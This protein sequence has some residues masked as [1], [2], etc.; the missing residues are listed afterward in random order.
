MLPKYFEGKL[1]LS[2]YYVEQWMGQLQHP[3]IFQNKQ[4]G[5]VLAWVYLSR[6]QN[7]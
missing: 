3:F 4:N 5:G 7:S 6:P 1:P 2:I